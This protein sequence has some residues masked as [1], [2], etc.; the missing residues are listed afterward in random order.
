MTISHLHP[1]VLTST[2]IHPQ[3]LVP[4]PV[5]TCFGIPVTHQ[6]GGHH[7]FKPLGLGLVVEVHTAHE[8][9]SCKGQGHCLSLLTRAALC[10]LHPM[11]AMEAKKGATQHYE[12]LASGVHLNLTPD[13]KNSGRGFLSKSACTV[14]VWVLRGPSVYHEPQKCFLL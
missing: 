1:I 13:A 7:L 5:G 4:T 10:H 3:L 8:V 14:W 12:R 6:R 11:A 9:I 2:S